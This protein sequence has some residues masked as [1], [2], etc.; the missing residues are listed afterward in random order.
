MRSMLGLF[1][2]LIFTFVNSDS[3]N[4]TEAKVSIP[5]SGRTVA[6]LRGEYYNIFP[7]RNRNAA[8]HRWATFLIE[9]ARSLERT[10]FE[11]MFGGFC[12]VS[13]SPIGSPGPRTLWKMSL[14][15]AGSSETITGGIHFCC[16]PCVCDTADFIRVDT[17]TVEV[18]DGTYQFNFLVLGNPCEKD[19]SL[20]PYQAPDA[21]CN[22]KELVKAT[23]SDNGYIIIGLLQDLSNTSSQD[24]VQVA[25]HCEHRANTG[26]RSGMGTIFREVAGI[27]PI[28]AQLQLGSAMHD[29][30]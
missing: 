13:G 6:D 21:K 29:E 28:P 23:Y 3:Q 25:D 4:E 12:P 22:G 7:N 19:S 15:W 16:W 24:E 30:L 11:E 10:T 1:F 2:L 20:I 27:N 26:Y 17:K 8:S 5:W 18:K 14:P 9:R